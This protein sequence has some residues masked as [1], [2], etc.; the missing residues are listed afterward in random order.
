MQYRKLAFKFPKSAKCKHSARYS[1]PVNGK[2]S[3]FPLAALF[4]QLSKCMVYAL[5]RVPVRSGV[6]AVLSS[7]RPCFMLPARLLA[8]FRPRSAWF[9]ILVL[10]PVSRLTLPAF[11]CLLTFKSISHF[12]LFVKLE[13]R[14]FR[15]WLESK[16]RRSLDVSDYST[17]GFVCQELFSSV[18]AMP[19]PAIASSQCRPAFRCAAV[20]SST[21]CMIPHAAP[22]VNHEFSLF[23]RPDLSELTFSVFLELLAAVCI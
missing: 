20:V 1:T 9:F 13:F 6:P 12:R 18:C 4:T 22:F 17:S 2:C 3:F 21:V 19:S 11:A 16:Q 15:F 10:R 14:S 7:C 5:L 23:R 8:C